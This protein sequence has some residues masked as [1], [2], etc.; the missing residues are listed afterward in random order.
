MILLKSI[1]KTSQPEGAITKTQDLITII[2]IPII[3][4]TIR[5]P[6]LK[7]RL[8][9]TILST[10]KTIR[11]FLTVKIGGVVTLPMNIVTKEMKEEDQTTSIISMTKEVI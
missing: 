2:L 1:T 6:K 5:I 11:T 7:H 10:I 3:R 4:I 9:S 8:P